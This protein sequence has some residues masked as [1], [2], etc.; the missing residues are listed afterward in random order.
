MFSRIG[1][2]ISTTS[3]VWKTLD[4]E[5]RVIIYHNVQNSPLVYPPPLLSIMFTLNR[6]DKPNKSFSGWVAAADVA[7]TSS[8][9]AFNSKISHHFYRV[10]VKGSWRC[11]CCV[12]ISWIEN[13]HHINGSVLFCFQFY[14]PFQNVYTLCSWQMTTSKFL[15]R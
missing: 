15:L 7:V 4:F 5:I 11:V 10:R 14:W 13:N 6:I 9:S 12:I 3:C 8:V 1:S 2:E